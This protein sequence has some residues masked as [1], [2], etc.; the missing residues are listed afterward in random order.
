[1]AE[2][3][4]EEAHQSAGSRLIRLVVNNS[5]DSRR[6]GRPLEA[7]VQT[8]EHGVSSDVKKLQER[9]V[10]WVACMRDTSCTKF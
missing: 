4:H 6:Q 9:M 5:S 7:M 2:F 3:E 1:M 10:R 8:K